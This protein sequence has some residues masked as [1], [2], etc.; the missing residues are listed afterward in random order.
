MPQIEL[1]TGLKGVDA[2]PY[3]RE[4]VRNLIYSNGKLKGRPVVDNFLDL[5]EEGSPSACRGLG[6]IRDFDTGDEELYGVWANKL[7]RITI[8]NPQFGKRLTADDVTIEVVGDIADQAEVKIVADFSRACIMVVGGPAYV[9]DIAGG[10][11]TQIS[12]SNYLPS[13]EVVVDDGRFVFAPIDGSPFFHTD[14]SNPANI[15]PRIFDA[16]TKPDPNK[17]LYVR[18][19]LLYALGSRSVEAL[20][21]RVQLDNYQRVSQNTDKVGFVSCLTQYGDNFCFLGQGDNGGFEFYQYGTVAEK[22]S[23]ETVSEILN[24]DYYERELRNLR[25]TYF[26]WEG[27]PCAVFLLPRHTLV[28]YGDWC[29]WQTGLS[30][31]EKL[32]TWRTNDVQFVYGYYWTGDSVD[33]SVGNLVYDNSEYG[34]P[35]EWLIDTFVKAEPQE[36]FRINNIY[37]DVTAGTSPDSRIS[38]TVCT[39]GKIYGPDRWYSTGDFADYK[40][41]VRLGPNVGRFTGYMGLRIRG[42]GDIG[43]NI[44]GVFIDY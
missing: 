24:K 35:V 7:K 30:G 41:T 19:G 25:A 12:D 3:Q 42:Y 28:Y 21:Y 4:T 5:G 31:G 22:I 1:P 9:Y 43:L 36:R 23:S 2:S 29:V 44:D 33:G 17:S 32:N 14:L 13:A 20:D 6:L 27:T 11:L 16:E 8:T 34:Q 39:E 18:R 40:T 37:T 15:E 26:V 10:T 38:M